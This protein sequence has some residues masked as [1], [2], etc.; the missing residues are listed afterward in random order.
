[1]ADLQNEDGTCKAPN[2]S[3]S[4][5]P[6]NNDNDVPLQCGLYLAES[7]IPNAGWGMYTGI[8]LEE[9]QVIPPVDV[10]IPVIDSEVHMTYL[11]HYKR[12]EQTLGSAVT[13]KSQGFKPAPYFRNSTAVKPTPKWLMDQYYWDCGMT[14]NY[15]DAEHIDSVVPGLGMLANSHPGMIMAENMGPARPPILG[16]RQFASRTPYQDQSFTA[17]EDIDAGH[18]IFVEVRKND[19]TVT[20]AGS[21]VQGVKHKQALTTQTNLILFN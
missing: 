21:E 18:E 17:L 5:P 8:E 19:V 16:G 9:G 6:T 1:M 3:T 2:A 7:S 12:L 10:V 4:T 14:H 13:G 15:Y 11:K 20:D